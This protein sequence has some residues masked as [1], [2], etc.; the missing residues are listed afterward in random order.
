[1][2]VPDATRLVQ[3]SASGIGLSNSGMGAV[4]QHFAT[5][6]A[7]TSAVTAPILNQ[8]T[9]LDS[10][11]G[12]IDYWNGTIWTPLLDQINVSA[13]SPALL[14]LS[15]PY[16]ANTPVTQYLKQVS[17]TAD[18]NGVVTLLGAADLTGRA[19]VLD[20]QFQEMG[21]VP[22]RVLVGTSG[23]TV[24][25]TAYLLT[26]GAPAA[27]ATVTGMIRAYLY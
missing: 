25:G 3:T 18:T 13:Q 1:M 19:G 11:P 23:S 14:Q 26:T 10:N 22:L 2:V 16:A 4:V 20:L 8:M 6:A 27:N 17:L 7:R 21:T 24:I 12:R 9:M 5:A 15:G